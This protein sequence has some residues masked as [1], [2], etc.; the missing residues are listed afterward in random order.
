MSSSNSGSNVIVKVLPNSNHKEK[1]GMYKSNEF[2][3]KP[4]KL[5]RSADKKVNGLEKSKL[6]NVSY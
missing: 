1:N 2:L 3:P 6:N 5:E 4:Q